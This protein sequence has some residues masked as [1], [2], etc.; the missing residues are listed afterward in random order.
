MCSKTAKWT[1]MIDEIEINFN[2][3]CDAFR[4]TLSE[5]EN[6]Q[7]KEL[8]PFS[9]VCFVFPKKR[10]KSFVYTPTNAR[11][12]AR[13]HKGHCTLFCTP[14]PHICVETTF[15]PSKLSAPK[16]HSKWVMSS[17]LRSRFEVG[18]RNENILTG[19]CQGNDSRWHKTQKEVMGNSHSQFISQRSGEMRSFL[20]SDYAAMYAGVFFYFWGW[21]SMVLMLNWIFI[22][23]DSVRM[24]CWFKGWCFA[25]VTQCDSVSRFGRIFEVN[26]KS[27]EALKSFRCSICKE[28]I[29]KCIWLTP[30]TA[31]GSCHCLKRGLKWC[32]FR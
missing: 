5:R 25:Y 12:R 1:R 20:T 9:V 26:L 23:L 30:G 8:A 19:G 18:R 22:A 6:F 21:N 14:L 2:E 11:V 10:I 29:S 3:G 16:L 15:H 7:N 32:C 31:R 24:W 28:N 17:A 4:R 13:W 27:L